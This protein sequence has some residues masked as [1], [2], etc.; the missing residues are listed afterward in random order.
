MT[1]IPP[2]LTRV[3]S[4]YGSSLSLSNLNRNNVALLRVQEQIQTGR[5]ISRVSDDIVRAAAIGVLDDRLERSVQQLRNLQHA[6]SSLNTIDNTLDL[7]VSVVRQAQTIASDQV[8]ITSST[9]ERASQAVVVDEILT[10]LTNVA[11]R[12]SVAGYV[13][14]G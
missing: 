6:Q 11:N 1:I 4:F 7:A 3:P 10:S 12:Q 13:M 8:S 9:T 14:G 2:N 5:A